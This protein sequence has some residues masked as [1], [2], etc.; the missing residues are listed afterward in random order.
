MN[1]NSLT[2]LVKR[3][4]TENPKFFKK[5]Q[6]AALVMGSISAGLVFFVSHGTNMPSWLVELSKDLAMASVGIVATAQLPNKDIN[7]K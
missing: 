6:V 3:M 1:Q 4:I 2:E 7:Q 5:I